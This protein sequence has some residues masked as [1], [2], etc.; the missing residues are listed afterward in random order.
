MI[1]AK[2]CRNATGFFGPILPSYQLGV[3]TGLDNELDRRPLLSVDLDI[4]KGGDTDEVQSTRG[5]KPAC[6]RYG[7]DGLVERS[8]ADR[9]DLCTAPLSNHSSDGAGHG[10]GIGFRRDFEYFHVWFNSQRKVGSPDVLHLYD[11]PR[12]PLVYC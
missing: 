4:R 8:R 12:V 7:L 5:H 1:R 3:L 10:I 6:D 11:T 9:L 2:A